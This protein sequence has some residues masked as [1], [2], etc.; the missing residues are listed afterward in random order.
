[1]RES[2]QREITEIGKT[3]ASKKIVSTLDLTPIAETSEEQTLKSKIKLLIRGQH[4][5]SKSDKR[6][7]NKLNEFSQ[8]EVSSHAAK[9]QPKPDLESPPCQN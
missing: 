6:P 2:E 3:S 9:S 7:A 8:V 1:M 5:N 4:Q